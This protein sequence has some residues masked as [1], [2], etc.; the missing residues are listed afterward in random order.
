[1]EKIRLLGDRVLLALVREDVQ[2]EQ[3]IGGIILPANTTA[4]EL[5]K[6]QPHFTV[7]GLGE[8]EHKFRVAVDDVVILNRNAESGINQVHLNGQVF[9]WVREMEIAGVITGTKEESL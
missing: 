2:K 1:M 9:I 6:A 3:Q 5:G 8:G 7:V 4:R